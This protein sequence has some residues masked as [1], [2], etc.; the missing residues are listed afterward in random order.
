MTT[1]SE[2]CS[3]FAL[4]ILD[5]DTARSGPIVLRA[6]QRA[7]WQCTGGGPAFLRTCSRTRKPYIHVKAL[8]EICRNERGS[9]ARFGFRGRQTLLARDM[10]TAAEIAVCM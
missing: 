5:R 10:L 4:D 7:I 3:V 6:T 1:S 9:Q 8:L 2:L